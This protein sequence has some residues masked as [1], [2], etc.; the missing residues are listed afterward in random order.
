[1]ASLL[2]FLSTWLMVTSWL[3]LDVLPAPILMNFSTK[4]LVDPRRQYRVSSW[5]G[6]RVVELLGRDKYASLWV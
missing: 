5:V 1:M 4:V 2:T 6:N 3:L